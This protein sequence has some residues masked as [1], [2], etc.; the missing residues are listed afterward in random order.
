MSRCPRGR[1]SVSRSRAVWTPRWP[2]PGCGRTAP[3]PARTRPTSAST[4]NPTCPA[5]PD[6]ARRVRRGDRPHRRLPRRAGR[7][8]PRRAGLRCVPHPVGGADLLQHHPAGPGRHR[9]PA[10]SRHGRRRGRHL[11]RRVDLQGQRHRA[12]LPLRPAGQPAAAHLQAVA[13]PAV[14]R[15]AGRPGRDERMVAGSQPALP[16][17]HREGVLH[18]R[19]HLGRHPRGQAARA[20]GRQRRDRP[21]DHGRRALGPVG[22]DRAGGRHRCV[23]ARP[24]GRDQRGPARTRSTW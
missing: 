14:R 9:H 6:R 11:G 5:C 10:G 2:W 18:R 16:G 24:A 20:P 4:T 19:Q 17:L 3:C 23:R 22:C 15:G 8:G 12:V 7:G 21:A 1:R 13:G